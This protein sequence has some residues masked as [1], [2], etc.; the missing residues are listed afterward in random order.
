M[1]VTLQTDDKLNLTTHNI[2]E[3]A[4]SYRENHNWAL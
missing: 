2:I 4:T 3:N 1:S